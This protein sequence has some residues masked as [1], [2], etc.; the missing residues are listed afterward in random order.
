LREKLFTEADFFSE[1]AVLKGVTHGSP[2]IHVGGAHLVPAF[3]VFKIFDFIAFDFI[4]FIA[5][6]F[7]DLDNGGTLKKT[8]SESIA[9][10]IVGCIVGCSVVDVVVVVVIVV[11]VVVIVGC[12]VDIPHTTLWP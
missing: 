10:C 3:V 5:F 2:T 9:G 12:I 4:D 6:G 8:R 7:G 1:R 11:V